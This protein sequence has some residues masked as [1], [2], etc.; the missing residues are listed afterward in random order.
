MKRYIPTSF[1]Y[2]PLSSPFGA[3]TIV[4][5]GEDRAAQVQRVFLPNEQVLVQ[6]AVRAAAAGAVARTCPAIADVQQRLERYLN[7]EAVSFD[8]SIFAMEQCSEFQRRVLLAEYA[9]PRGSVSTYGRIARHLGDPGASRA[10]GGALASNPY[11]IVIPC[12]RAVRSDGHLGGFRGGLE[13]K[14]ALLEMEGVHVGPD[15]RVITEHFYY[16]R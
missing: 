4:W 8:L 3:L 12:H 11:P 10:V 5:D 13:M 6:E 15:S 14:R 2:V 7:G 1:F 16:S 9:I